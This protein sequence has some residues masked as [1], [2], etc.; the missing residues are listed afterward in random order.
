[1]SMSTRIAEELPS[2]RHHA[3]ALTVGQETGSSPI[4]NMRF[5]ALP[6]L[7]NEPWTWAF[8]RHQI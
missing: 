2:L 1:M 7:A 4:R 3:R 5:P 8:N 6:R